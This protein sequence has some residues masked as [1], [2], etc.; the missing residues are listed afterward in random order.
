MARILIVEDEIVSALM[1]QEFLEHSE[2]TVVASV[3]SGSEA[4]RVAVEVQPDLVLMDILLEGG[5]DGITAA[6]Q[7]HEQLGVPIIYITANAEDQ[8][9]QRAVATGPFGYLVKPFNQIGL[10]TTVNIALHHCELEQQ[11][12]QAEQWLATTLASIGDGTI[13]TDRKGCI[14]F[15]NAA[16]EAL[17]GWQQAEA[18]GTPANLI[19]R[20]IH[21]ETRDAIESPALTGDSTRKECEHRGSLFVAN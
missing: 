4:V 18:L 9:L 19:L 3:T 10:Y 15:M 2:H 16:A 5:L 21:A 20:L 17:T 14:T 7:I 6:T 13:A 12:E 11:L 1:I 8:T